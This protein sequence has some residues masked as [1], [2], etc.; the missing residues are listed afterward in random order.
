MQALKAFK[1]EHDGDCNVPQKYKDSAGHGLGRW[2]ERQRLPTAE[3]SP[4]QRDQLTA[5][6]FDWETQ[7][8]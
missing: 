7:Q 4:E 3:L 2:V 5:I 1:A 8:G 6:G